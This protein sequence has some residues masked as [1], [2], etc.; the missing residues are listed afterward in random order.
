MENINLLDFK[1]AV[2]KDIKIVGDTE[3]NYSISI[4]MEDGKELHFMR[5]MKNDEATIDIFKK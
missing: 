5:S 1:G 4:I 2:I 3:V